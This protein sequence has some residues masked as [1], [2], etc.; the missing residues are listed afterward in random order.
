MICFV[1]LLNHA[2][3]CR[4]QWLFFMSNA[5]WWHVPWKEICLN[6]FSPRNSNEWS[7]IY[8]RIVHS[9]VFFFYALNSWRSTMVLDQHFSSSHV[10]DDDAVDQHHSYK[11]NVYYRWHA[12]NS[13]IYIHIY[14]YM[15]VCIYVWVSCNSWTSNICVKLVFRL[16]FISSLV[17]Y[18]FVRFVHLRCFLPKNSFDCQLISKKRKIIPTF[19]HK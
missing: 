6:R 11:L 12:Y 1:C 10:D 7:M 14:I 15:C 13:S 18:I 8:L 19:K 16:K 4:C 17:D 2:F 9:C 5:Y 3:T